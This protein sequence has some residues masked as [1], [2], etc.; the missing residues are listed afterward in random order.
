MLCRADLGTGRVTGEVIKHNNQTILMR[1]KENTGKGAIYVPDR[2]IGKLIK[3]HIVKHRITFEE[4]QAKNK[5]QIWSSL[6]F[7]S[8]METYIEHPE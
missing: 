8:R 7:L 1:L 2:K 3:R 6:F 5:D 4:E